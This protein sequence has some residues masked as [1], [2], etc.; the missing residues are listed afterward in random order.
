MT[1]SLVALLF[2]GGPATLFFVLGLSKNRL[3]PT[4]FWS[5]AVVCAIA[6]FIS[7]ALVSLSL[8]GRRR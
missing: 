5:L 1:E 7:V 2:V 3:P 8:R 6:A 4:M